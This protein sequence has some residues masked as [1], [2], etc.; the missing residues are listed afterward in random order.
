MHIAQTGAHFVH[1]ANSGCPASSQEAELESAVV[2]VSFTLVPGVG[3]EEAVDKETPRLTV[4]PVSAVIQILPFVAVVDSTLVWRRG[5][6]WGTGR[7]RP[8]M[9]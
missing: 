4:L 1:Y 5:L 7:V 2:A 3:R 9:S 6:R 8:G